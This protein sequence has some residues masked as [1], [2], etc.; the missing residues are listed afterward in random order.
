MHKV[1]YKVL[2]LLAVL[3]VVY[4][5]SISYGKFAHQVLYGA[6]I[7]VAHSMISVQ[8]V[9]LAK[10]MLAFTY[11][12]NWQVI[13]SIEALLLVILFFAH[14]KSVALLT[15]VTLVGGELLSWICKIYSQRARP[16]YWNYLSVTGRDSFP[17][18]HALVAV[19]FYGLCAYILCRYL[20]KKWQKRLAVVV[21]TVIALLVGVSRIY[22][23]VHWFSDVIGGWILGGIILISLISIFQ[24]MHVS[25]ENAAVHTG[26]ELNLFIILVLVLCEGF[27]LYYFYTANPLVEPQRL[28]DSF[29]V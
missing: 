12:G 17:S 1:R 14:R 6:D 3:F 28:Q 20:E 21:A 4:F 27:F 23:G 19:A 29:R 22:L 7:A 16:E 13:V 9:S 5:L 8:S 25:R 10:I 15:L 18:G 11:L 24:H 26:H 2:I